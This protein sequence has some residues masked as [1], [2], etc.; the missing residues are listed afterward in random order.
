[1]PEL[2]SIYKDHPNYLAFKSWDSRV[3]PGDIDKQLCLKGLSGSSRSLFIASCIAQKG[4]LHWFII[5]EREE[6]A[7][8]Y[9]D[10]S[11]VSDQE[12]VMLFP[13]AYKRSVNENEVDESGLILRTAVLNSLKK[14]KET[15]KLIVVTY[16]EAIMEKVVTSDSLNKN[17]L[18]LKV[19]EK[20]S[21][22]FIREV[23]EEYRFEE[24]EFVYE[25]GQFSVR[26]S[27]VDIFSYS[28]HLPFRIDFFG[29]DVESIR[30]FEVETQLSREKLE[31]I[32]IIP[33][34][35]KLVSEDSGD[36]VLKLLPK[37][38]IIWSD[39]LNYSIDRI[40]DIYNGAS[41]KII[42]ELS[43]EKILRENILQHSEEVRLLLDQFKQVEFGQGCA[44][45]EVLEFNT[46]PQ[47]VFKKNFEL[48]SQ[49]LY[50]YKEKDYTLLLLSENPK[51]IERLK[52][53][54][55]SLPEQVTFDPVVNSIHEGFIDH[56]LKIC[57]YTDH[58]IFERYHK[59]QINK[60]F[61]RSE[62]FTINELRGLQKGDYV[63]HIDHGIGTFGGL[64]RNEIN[65]HIQETICLIYKDNDVVQVNIHN[66]HKISKYRGKDGTPPKIYK[67]GTAAWEN[68]KQSTK[69]KVKDIARELI[70]LY[71]KR[72]ASEGFA[73]APDTYLQEELEASFIYEDT[74][75]QLK[76]TKSVKEGMES[77]HPMDHL[78]C[79]D[80]GFGKTEIAVRAAFKA[81]ADNKQVAVL[82]PTTILAL[83]HYN[84]FKERL[85]K[86]PCTVDYISRLKSAKDQK[87]TLKKLEA[88]QIDIIIGTH[89]LIGKDIKFKDL[90][91]LVIDEEQKFGVAVKEKLKSLR[92]NID[93][94]TMTATPIPRTLQFSLMGARDLSII[95]T[96]P[97]NR[98][99]IQTEL[100]TFDN[101]VIKDA[102]EYEV[103]RGG[104]VFFIHNRVDNLPAMEI[105]INKLC[106]HVKTVIAHGQMD[107]DKLERIVL[108]YIRGDYDVLIST[109]IIESGLDI[110]NANT[111]IINQ[112]QNFGLSDLHQLRGRVGRSNKKAFCY[113]MAAPYNVLTPEAR[114]RLKAIEEFTELG[115]GFNIAMQDLDIRGA[116]NLL[117]AEQSGFIAEIGL[118]TYQRILNEAM[119][120][121]REEEFSDLFKE[122]SDPNK[123]SAPHQYTADCQIDTDLELLF[124]DDYIR[125][126][127]ERIRLYRELDD[128]ENEEKLKEYEQQLTDR[129][130]AI[131]EPTRE[132]MNVVRM[133]WIAGQLGFEK[134]ILKNGKMLI[135]F[136][137]N[138][139]SPYYQSPVF[140]KIIRFVQKNPF[141]FQ[142]KEAR[143]KL[144]MISESVNSISEAMKTLKKIQSF[145]V[146]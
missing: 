105:L 84:T 23:L 65:G 140:E 30:T 16:P 39:N 124:P 107:G 54:F 26:G 79:G 13:S 78:I 8:F 118:E 114:R 37:G 93:T 71:A 115:S 130:G 92:V 11:H 63:V 74:P 5:P 95:N 126:V 62:V 87:E 47:P 116:G 106:P 125:N 83:Q 77:P 141:L 17:T 59:Y 113:L 44:C 139:M 111:I 66:L 98:H 103:D 104:Q 69:K 67:L 137:A 85:E 35:Q 80:V 24:T 9:N 32:S 146:S 121:L 38:T 55:T 127:S 6:A 109:I 56:N 90:G 100:H 10:L 142:M 101:K 64:G 14:I 57:L 86:F 31:V 129:F 102:I 112:A 81:V 42:S 28:S 27:I 82:V 145:V 33:N 99:P 58:Q 128:I 18:E 91:L 4:G 12:S 19:N 52:D 61:V 22:G 29:D 2:I 48:L 45:P 97:P 21:I 68:M 72:K 53:I 144:T 135:W 60:Q 123:E 138:Q 122:E 75:D 89:R 119:L 50:E 132:L 41:E 49:N 108:D 136:V 110:A 131:P 134:I 25:P 143:D 76:A 70:A 88:G 117:G 51:Q 133:R 46:A 1:L 96:P 94:L 36:S 40:N 20:I 43:K 3:K 73:Y 34:I 7:Y 15:D 120:E